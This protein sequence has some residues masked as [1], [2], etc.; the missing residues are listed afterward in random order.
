[1]NCPTEAELI[2][3][4]QLVVQIMVMA[5]DVMDKNIGNLR[6]ERWRKAF[7]TESDASV[8]LRNRK[9]TKVLEHLIQASD[10]SHTMQ[11]WQIY[12]RWN[13][14]LFMEMYHAY[15]QG[16]LQSDPS[17]GWYQGE[18]GFLDFYVIPLAKKL[19]ACGVFGV[20]SDEFLV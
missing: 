9:G 15:K 4:R 12:H 5:T 14:K 6:K 10:V 18:I 16:R 8:E 20:S 17:K 19:N 1:L 7:E 13:K 3:F 11:H 2:Q